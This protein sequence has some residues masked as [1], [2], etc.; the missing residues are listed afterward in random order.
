VDIPALCKFTSV[1]KY[2]SGRFKID[3]A[4]AWLHIIYNQLLHSS[5]NMN[6]CIYSKVA[7]NHDESPQP[8]ASVSNKHMHEV[9]NNSA[10][11][12]AVLMCQ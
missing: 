1:L 7:A 5:S 2:P 6:Y 11:I 8:S 10:H 12:V 3:H 4:A 9:G